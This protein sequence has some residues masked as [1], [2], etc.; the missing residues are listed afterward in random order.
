M[1]GGTDISSG[2]SI[3]NNTPDAVCMTAPDG[4][5]TRSVLGGI[6]PVRY[7]LGIGLHPFDFIATN[8]GGDAAQ[9][10]SADNG[11]VALAQQQGNSRNPRRC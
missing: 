3:G 10:A 2:K 5:P 11:A 4:D 1:P 9:D 8:R 7:Q 6:I